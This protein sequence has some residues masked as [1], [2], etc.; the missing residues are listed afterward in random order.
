MKSKEKFIFTVGMLVMIF[1]A[2]YTSYKAG[3]RK[4]ITKTQ[5]KEIKVSEKKVKTYKKE[6]DSLQKEYDKL[7]Q[8]KQEVKKIYLKGKEKITLITEERIQQYNDTLCQKDVQQLKEQ[9]Y[10][11][12]SLVDIQNIQLEKN[13]HQLNLSKLIIDEKDKEIGIY[14]NKKS[15]IKPVGIGIFG[16]YGTDFKNGWTPT[17]GVGISY[18]FIRF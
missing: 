4:V 12:D 6:Y 16:G 10:Q 7:E 15:K 9:A 17:V 11:C 13:K 14:K 3:K 1:A 18:N 8:V 5:Q 2:C